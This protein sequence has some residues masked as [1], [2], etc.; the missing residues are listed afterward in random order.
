M[1]CPQSMLW[2]I[3]Q[4]LSTFLTLLL[5]TII[6]QAPSS[7]LQLWLKVVSHYNVTHLELTKP[8]RRPLWIDRNQSVFACLRRSH[9][10]FAASLSAAA[11]SRSNR[12]AIWQALSPTRRAR[13]CV[14]RPSQRPRLRPALYA[15]PRPTIKATLFCPRCRPANT[16]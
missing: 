6:F 7:H 9:H 2:I 15:A 1:S 5:A 8:N 4:F 14:A 13:S 10:C 11:L 12:W 3:F 16:S